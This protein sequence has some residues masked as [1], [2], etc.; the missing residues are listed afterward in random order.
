MIRKSEPM[1][2]VPDMRATVQWYRSLGFTV[3]GEHERDGAL[4]F[5]HVTYGGGAF[6]IGPGASPP[7][8]VSLW[9][10]TDDIDAVHAHMKARG[11]PFAEAMY[12]PFYGGRQFSICDCNGLNL[13][14]WQ[15]E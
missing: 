3:E 2:S 11:V 6:A 9:F 10:F 8:G 5:A 7:S 13:I 12:H 15:P 1:F 14:F 4:V